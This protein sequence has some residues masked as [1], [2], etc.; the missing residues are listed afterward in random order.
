MEGDR[1]PEPFLQTQ[2]DDHV[3]MFS[4]N[5][6][7]IAYQ[8]NESG[9]SEV[10]VRSFP[11]AERK[12]QVS[13]EGGTSPVWNPNGRELFYRNGNKMMAVDVEMVG[14]V[15]LGEPKV[16]FEMPGFLDR[17]D[18]TPDGQRFVM[19]EEGESQPAPAHLVLVQNWGEELKRLVPAN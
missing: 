4:P 7:W 1:K 5:G 9:Q 12:R 11:G 16:L 17:F 19:I 15:K 14:E 10:Y 8:S 13:T 2:F 6:R 3:P 18:V